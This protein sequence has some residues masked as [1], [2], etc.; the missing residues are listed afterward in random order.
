VLDFP[1]VASCAAA[2][3][4][5]NAAAMAIA[6][7]HFIVS[8]SWLSAPPKLSNQNCAYL[9]SFLHLGFAF[10]ANAISARPT[11]IRE[12]GTAAG[13]LEILQHFS[14]A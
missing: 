1:L 9:T 7:M 5:K 10:V 2:G 8:S 13:K 4:A 11:S 3:N 12:Q 6:K 14:G